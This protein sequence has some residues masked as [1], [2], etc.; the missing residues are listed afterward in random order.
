MLKVFF[1][2]T[3]ILY[4]KQHCQW[5]HHCM[6]YK[7]AVLSTDVTELCA[8]SALMLLVGHQ[9][10][11]PVCKN[12]VMRCCYSFLSGAR[13]RL[14]AYG[15]ADATASQNPI[16]SCLIEIQ[17]AFTFLV[18]A[19]PGC[20][21]KEPVKWVYC[22]CS[23]S[24]VGVW[25]SVRC[26]LL[27]G[28]QEATAHA[29]VGSQQARCWTQSHVSVLTCQPELTVSLV[30]VKKSKG[31]PYSIT[32]R[33]VPEVIPVLGSQPAGDVSHKPYSSCLL[34]TSPSPRD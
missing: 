31:S 30:R 7:W 23:S 3:A 17:T 24:R 10:E 21:G 12:W 19:Y 32:K 16:V 1:Q 29:R 33:R 25:M 5:A 8:F 11:H 28:I 20:P 14:F 26:L 34:Y 15:P 2:I 18:P 22:S 13:C 9:E 27:G 6:F 4:L